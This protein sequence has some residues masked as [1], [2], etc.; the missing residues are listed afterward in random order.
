VEFAATDIATGSED[1]YLQVLTRVAGAALAATY[2]F[3]ATAANKAIFTHANAADRTYTLPDASTTVVGTDTTQTLTAKI[4]V[5]A[6]LTGTPLQHGLYQQNVPKAWASV[7]NAATTY[8]L[9]DSFN[10]ASVTDGATGIFTLTW[11]RDFAN[12]TYVM[13]DSV[14]GGGNAD[15]TNRATGSADFQVRDNAGNAADRTAHVI[16]F[17]D[18]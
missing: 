5:P 1:T 13:A 15:I 9:E 6:A 16:L 4:L 12:T 18:Q 11:D 10:C 17:G 7:T 2:R 3:A 8:S 14:I